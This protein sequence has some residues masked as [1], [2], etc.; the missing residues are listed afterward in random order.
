MLDGAKPNF[1][2]TKLDPNLLATPFRFQTNWHVITGAACTGK[3]TLINQLA[4]KGFQTA[5]ETA[6]EY[7][8]IELVRGRT[9]EEIRQNGATAQAG[10]LDLQLEIEGGLRPVEVTF[11][12]RAIPDSLTFHRVVGLNPNEILEECFHYRYASIF[13]LDRLPMARKTPLGPEDDA[14]SIFIDEWLVRDYSALGYQVVRVPV[15]PPAVRLAFVLDK[16]AEQ[17]LI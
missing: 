3:T 13:I 17:G 2:T 14:S 6:R 7:F 1:R 9:I 16:L 4:A 15:L 10:I 8:E 5:A 11:L 12:D